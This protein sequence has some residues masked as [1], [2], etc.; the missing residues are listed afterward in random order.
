[1]EIL[2]T[3]FVLD[4]GR[5]FMV[6]VVIPAKREDTG[7]VNKEQLNDAVLSSPT[8]NSEVRV[9]VAPVRSANQKKTFLKFG[10]ISVSVI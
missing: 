3:L 6:P 9:E 1:M 5:H 10:K 8:G 4:I 7:V 2:L